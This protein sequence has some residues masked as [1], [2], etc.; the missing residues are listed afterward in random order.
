MKR[1]VILIAHNNEKI[2]YYDMAIYTAKR[3]NKFLDLPVSVITDINSTKNTDVFDKIITVEP[4]TSNARHKAVWINKDRCNVFN[5]TPYDETLII[6]VDY[7]INSKTLLKTF[8]LPSDFVCHYDSKYFLDPTVN[9]KISNKSFSTFWA[10][11]MRFRKTSRTE[12]LFSIMKMIQENYKH[13]STLYEF[14]GSTYRNDYALTIALRTVNGQLALKH[15]NIPW[16]LLHVHQKSTVLRD[17]DISYTIVHTQDE[18]SKFITV[19]DTDFHM[20]NK[21]N[22]AD[23]ML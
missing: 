14:L 4:N 19:S 18:K 2:N 23:I 3:V 12:Q 6:D 21:K 7:M 20:L 22:F 1:G 5:L 11:V 9:E 8:Q 10:T 15:D 16:K 17:T 13:Y